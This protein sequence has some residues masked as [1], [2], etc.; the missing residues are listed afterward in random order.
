MVKTHIL[1]MAKTRKN[2]ALQ[3]RAP[4]LAALCMMR[5]RKWMLCLSAAKTGSALS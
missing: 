1:L 5:E 4:K 3:S 2:P